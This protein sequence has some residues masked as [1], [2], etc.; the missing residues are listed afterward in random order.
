MV[1]DKVPEELRNLTMLEE[2]LIARAHPI[3]NVY[4]KKGGQYGYCGHV[5]DIGRDVTTFATP[6]PWNGNSEDVPIIVIQPPDGRAWEGRDFIASAYRMQR[7]LVYLITHNP[8]DA[9]VRIDLDHL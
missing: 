9:G 6:L 8:G 2:Q 3:V 4:R 5:I 1:P 7:A